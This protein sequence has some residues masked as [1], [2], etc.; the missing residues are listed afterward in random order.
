MEECYHFALSYVLCV[1]VCALIKDVILVSQASCG[2]GDFFL[3]FKGLETR[4][5]CKC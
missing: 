2:E 4:A 5:E 1:F 3:N